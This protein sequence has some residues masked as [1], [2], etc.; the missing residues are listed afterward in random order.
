M[1]N[2]TE[3]ADIRDIKGLEHFSYSPVF[4]IIPALLLV[5]LAWLAYRLYKKRAGRVKVGTFAPPPPDK[6]ALRELEL[7]LKDGKY[8][9]LGEKR[10]NFRLSEIF[11]N[12]L[13]GRY[14]FP[15]SDMTTEEII[16]LLKK[17]KS[18][19][20]ALSEEIINILSETDKVKF[21]KFRPGKNFAAGLVQRAIKF[22]NETKEII[23]EEAREENS[24]SES[25]L[26]SA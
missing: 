24:G 8:E 18:I 10:F 16:S 1:N 4:Y 14:S 15:A 11:R 5:V 17:E 7:L 21:A 19:S 3:Q 9:G 20:S 13:E 25:L 22:V 12:Y 6:I 23:T 2:A 26:P